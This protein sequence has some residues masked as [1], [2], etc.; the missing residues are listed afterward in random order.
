MEVCALARQAPAKQRSESLSF[1]STLRAYRQG[2][3]HVV[4]IV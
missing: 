4:G 2:S 1:V 3:P